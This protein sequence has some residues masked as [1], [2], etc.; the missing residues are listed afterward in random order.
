[1]TLTG[2]GYSLSGTNLSTIRVTGDSSDTASLT[3]STGNDGVYGAPTFTSIYGTG[4]NEVASNF[5]QVSVQGGGGSDTANLYDSSG[6]DTFT[7]SPTSATL[8]GDRL[9]QHCLGDGQGIRP[10]HHGQRH[11]HT[12]RLHRQRRGL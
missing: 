6:D 7:A 10:C 4:F 9:Q 1:M 2:P 11:R 12:H 8:S 3:G 5:K